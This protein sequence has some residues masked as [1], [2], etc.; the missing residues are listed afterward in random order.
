MGGGGGWCTPII[1]LNPTVS[2]QSELELELSVGLGFDNYMFTGLQDY[3][4]NV[5]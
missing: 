3:S 5:F 4:C 2:C 1:V